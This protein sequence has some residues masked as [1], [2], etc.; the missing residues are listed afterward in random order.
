MYF[1]STLTTWENFNPPY[2]GQQG[3]DYVSW[4]CH[5][6]NWDDI[7][8][9]ISTE[10]GK[11]RNA[12]S[13]WPSAGPLTWPD[14]SQ[15]T[16]E[17]HSYISRYFTYDSDIVPAFAG[18]A[19]AL[20]KVF[21]GGILYGLP[22]VFFD[23][24]L[25]WTFD[26][27]QAIRAVDKTSDESL[28]APS[29]SWMSWRGKFA[30]GSWHRFAQTLG[31]IAG[32]Y[33][34]WSYD[35]MIYSPIVQW[36]YIGAGGARITIENGHSK[37]RHF[38]HDSESTPPLGWDRITPS[39]IDPKHQLKFYCTTRAAPGH[40]FRFPI[41]LVDPSDAVVTIP[42]PTSSV[43]TCQ[44]ERAYFYL[45]GEHAFENWNALSIIDSKGHNSGRFLEFGDT[46]GPTKVNQKVELIAISYSL[47][48][49]IN[50]CE[51]TLLMGNRRTEDQT[52]GGVKEWYNVLWIEWTD[53]IAYRRAVGQVTKE[54]WGAADREHIHVKLG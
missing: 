42:K 36:S 31:T 29:W 39:T 21:P 10:S 54:A 34:S 27:I 11:R 8:G 9:R 15:Y 1:L 25:M 18:T 3:S 38:A 26:E 44:T 51:Q 46:H 53:D 37:Y 45:A 2:F 7:G 16:S 5:R 12:T 22:I 30:H 13:I 48:G 32:G 41:P 40:M 52:D 23:V 6:A 24:A 19:S 47:Q 43:I 4:N 50:D 35:T 17:V 20:A 14:F 28:R 33:P 49:N